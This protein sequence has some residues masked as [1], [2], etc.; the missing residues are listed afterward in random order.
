MNRGKA[1]EKMLNNSFRKTKIKTTVKPLHTPVPMT[2]NNNNNNK[3][4]LEN[5]SWW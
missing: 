1:H 4:K 2:N 5:I 3:I